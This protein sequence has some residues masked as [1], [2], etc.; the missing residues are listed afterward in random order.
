MT[1]YKFYMLLSQIQHANLLNRGILWTQ[2]QKPFSYFFKKSEQGFV[3][4]LVLYLQHRPSLFGLQHNADY[5]VKI[6]L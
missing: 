3:F 4:A 5:V 1:T 2:K 6:Y